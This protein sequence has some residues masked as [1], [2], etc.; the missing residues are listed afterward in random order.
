MNNTYELLETFQKDK[1]TWS[2]LRHKK[3]GLE[4]AYHQCESEETGFSFCFRTPVED[5]YL[6]TSHVLEH[7]VLQG[8]EK[9]DVSFLQLLRLSVYTYFNAETT[10]LRTRFFF[11]SLLEKECFKLI[12]IL[13]EYLF[14]PKLSEEIFMQECMRVEFDSKGDERKKE[15]VGVIY[16]EMKPC[17]PEEWLFGG[18]Y[19]KLHEL[20]NNK[21][22]EYHKKYYRPDNCLFVF[23]GNAAL[24]TVLKYVN[25]VVSEFEANNSIREIKPRS[26]LTIQEFLK[27]VPF[28]AAP[29]KLE[30]PKLAHWLNDKDEDICDQLE[31]YWLD[32]VSPLI[33]FCLDDKYA[34]SMVCWW[35]KNHPEVE[36]PPI[37]PKLT[38]PKIKASYLSQFTPEEYKEKLETLHKWQERDVREK[39]KK[40]M[41]PLIVIQYDI[42]W[43]AKDSKTDSEKQR[44]TSRIDD[45]F[46]KNYD[47]ITKTDKTSCSIEFRPSEYLCR[48]FN[49]EYALTL[50]LQMFLHKRLRQL[51]KLY[52]VGSVYDYPCSF[53][54]FTVNT[55]H[56]QKTVKI[57]KELIRE[58]QNYIFTQTD[59]LAVKSS[60]YSIVTTDKCPVSYF[61]EE[62]LTLT[63]EDLHQAA[64]RFSHMIE[65]PKQ[66][67]TYYYKIGDVVKVY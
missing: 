52:D 12:P 58:T 8:S 45:H 29:E 10:N 30:D 28:V 67:E 16:N 47:L 54:I 36:E 13:A 38:I 64:V 56:P 24:E 26:N 2:Y 4:I 5:P 33:Q 44:I 21:L 41:E 20:T 49:A 61:S 59:L 42:E 23:N 3:T 62:I 39:V 31:G 57:I 19:Y 6:G 53:K 40:I 65:P 50:F 63:P 43:L 18:S 9:Y 51:G 55:N 25:K 32:G 17:P 48:E 34:Y 14:F 22:R 66:D 60:I 1:E 27:N 37:P 35:K 7:C 15:I 11:Y 46:K